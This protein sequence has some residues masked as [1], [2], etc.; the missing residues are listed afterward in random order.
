MW[1]HK[2]QKKQ[3][4]LK[5]LRPLEAKP[6]MMAQDTHSLFTPRLGTELADI[7]T[8]L[9]SSASVHSE[10]E[11]VLSPSLSNNNVSSVSVTM[12]PH[13]SAVQLHSS[14]LDNLPADRSEATDGLQTD[15]ALP[16][17]SSPFM[18]GD[19]PLTTDDSQLVSQ[20][21]EDQK[22]PDDDTD[23]TAFGRMFTGISGRFRPEFYYWMSYQLSRPGLHEGS[24]LVRASL[25]A[26]VLLQFYWLY[27]S[28][29]CLDRKI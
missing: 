25:T 28:C 17:G 23:R 27:C 22:P 3:A 8:P 14:L 6:P 4:L 9:R 20:L 10:E 11:M 29:F 21:I 2:R 15:Y 24:Y 7:R 5:Y 1:W 13:A 18:R 12:G 16:G 26:Y 19:D